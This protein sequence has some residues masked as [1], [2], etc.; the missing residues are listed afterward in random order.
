MSSERKPLKN[1]QLYKML[2][3]CLE[4]VPDVNELAQLSKG[5]CILTHFDRL[6]ILKLL[7]TLDRVEMSLKRKH[8]THIIENAVKTVATSLTKRK[9]PT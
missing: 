4:K 6:I 3:H 5:H 9:D 7:Q 8:I 1:D 2:P